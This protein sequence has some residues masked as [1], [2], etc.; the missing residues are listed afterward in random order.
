VPAQHV[1][2]GRVG[3]GV[4]GDARSCAPE[5]GGGESRQTPGVATRGNS[6]IVSPSPPLG[7]P[8]VFTRKF[9]D[10][11]SASPRNPGGP[12]DH[13]LAVQSMALRESRQNRQTTWSIR[14][15]WRTMGEK[16]ER[17][18]RGG[19]QRERSDAGARSE[20]AERAR[21]PLRRV[22][23]PLES[24]RYR[25]AFIAREDTADSRARRDFAPS[26]LD[27]SFPFSRVPALRGGS[28][29]PRQRAR[30]PPLT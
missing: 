17:S 23:G 2:L 7:S 20:A 15:N 9:T 10:H 12:R 19:R 26:I 3:L 1:S 16:R 29:L 24:M 13:V 28:Y 14:V 6:E 25:A 11:P 21:S 18:R 5:R 22:L 30:P 8:R 27:P 4:G